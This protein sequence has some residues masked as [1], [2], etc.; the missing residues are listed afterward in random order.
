MSIMARRTTAENL[1]QINTRFAPDVILRLDV[2][3]CS[4]I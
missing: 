3:W 2:A 1:L 4:G